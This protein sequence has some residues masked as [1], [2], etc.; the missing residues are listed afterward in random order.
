RIVAGTPGLA[1]LS[2][3]CPTLGVMPA[4][5]GIEECR[6]LAAVAPP[7][8]KARLDPPR[9]ATAGWS[10]GAGEGTLDRRL[11]RR[12]VSQPQGAGTRSEGRLA[13]RGRSAHV[14]PH[15][16]SRVENQPGKHGSGRMGSN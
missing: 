4:A 16:A 1:T 7:F 6:P 11:D 12:R 9:A 3:R 13:T 10:F 15:L 2:H 8:P 5:L 14:L